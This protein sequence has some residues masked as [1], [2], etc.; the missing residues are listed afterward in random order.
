VA[1]YET[2]E[3]RVGKQTRRGRP[4]P[5]EP[6]RVTVVPIA[7][8]DEFFG[9]TPA[10]RTAHL[11]GCAALGLL[12]HD[13]QRLTKRVRVGGTT[14]SGHPRHERAYVFGCEAEDIPRRRR[15]R[16]PRERVLRW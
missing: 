7:D 4:T 8:S 5:T 12:V 3:F 1:V 13:R 6:M 9:T 11:R 15:A 10:T 14:P 16:R 2:D